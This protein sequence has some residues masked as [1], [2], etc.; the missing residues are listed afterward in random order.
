MGKSLSPGKRLVTGGVLEK[1][2]VTVNLV[3]Q[4]LSRKILMDVA[5]QALL[6]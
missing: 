5:I 1:T 3:S 2:L 6:S 4:E